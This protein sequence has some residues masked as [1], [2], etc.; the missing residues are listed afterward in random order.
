MGHRCTRMGK[1]HI[2][3]V[4]IGAP[5][6]ANDSFSS[7]GRPWR[8]QRRGDTCVARIFHGWRTEEGDTRVAPTS[9]ETGSRRT[10]GPSLWRSRTC[11][12]P[13]FPLVQTSRPATV[14]RASRPWSRGTPRCRTVRRPR[15]RAQ[16]ICSLMAVCHWA[17]CPPVSCSPHE[18][19]G[20]QAA[21][22]HTEGSAGVP[23]PWAGRPC[24]GER[25]LFWR[26]RLQQLLPPSDRI[27]PPSSGRS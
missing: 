8:F 4:R 10:C 2:R 22:W 6:A 7:T 21:Q 24:Y 13:V 15:S 25:D 23:T 11:S 12:S 18:P 5:S 17:A 19:R 14:A 27:P 20:G 1:P 3:S 9:C 26:C 16:A